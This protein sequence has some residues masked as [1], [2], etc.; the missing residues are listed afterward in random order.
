MEGS[1][2]NYYESLGDVEKKVLS[3]IYQKSIDTR[4]KSFTVFISE[5]KKKTKLNIYEIDIIMRLFNLKG[6]VFCELTGIK[7][8]VNKKYIVDLYYFE[9]QDYEK[10]N[11]SI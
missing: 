4:A 1:L 6:F 5:I 10:H 7:K 2:K 3:Y 11:K 8:G 9:R